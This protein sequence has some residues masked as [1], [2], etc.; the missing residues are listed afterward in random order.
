MKYTLSAR[1]VTRRA[2]ASGAVI[3]SQEIPT[4]LCDGDWYADI[5][6]GGDAEEILN[7]INRLDQEAA[8]YRAQFATEEEYLQHLDENAEG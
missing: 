8:S 2:L 4:I 6:A 5:P 1:T 3:S 7:T